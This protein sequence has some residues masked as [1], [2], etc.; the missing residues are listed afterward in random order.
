MRS[1]RKLATAVIV[2]GA[3]FAVGNAATGYWLREIR[4]FEET[5]NAYVR[6]HL[7]HISPE[8]SG[9]VQ[10]VH[11]TDHQQVRKG[12]LL[13]V[14]DD[15]EYRARVAHA[16]AALAAARARLLTLQADITVQDARVAQR[17]AD[18]RS[19]DAEVRRA[20]RD[21][22]RQRDLVRDGATSGQ[23]EDTAIAANASAGAR[24]AQA[25]A[26]FDEAA[27]QR[28]A[29]QARLDEGTAAVAVAEA[30]LRL[31]RINL[32]RTRIHAPVD[33]VLAERRVQL[34]QSVQPG[35]LIAQMVPQ[36]DLFVEANFKETQLGAMRPGQPV[37][38]EID[39]FEDVT[40][41]GVVTS[42]SPASGSE[43]SILPPEN[44]TGNFTKIV[45]RVPVRIDFQ[46]DALTENI[47]PGL[48]VTARVRVR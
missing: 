24:R 35:S 41:H 28:L 12:A 16:K 10:A 39:A 17:E 43:F 22:A 21:L 2:L 25:G 14:L 11:F 46:R 9:Y 34:G 40:F 45:R 4:P 7:A 23:A 42:T 18:I 27:R 8:I 38:L 13:V 6:S 19:V 29:M 26:A 48:S 5:D 44:A 36:G 15:R 20:G 47:K 31:A 1:A 32:A 3:L 33:G 30:E 37:L